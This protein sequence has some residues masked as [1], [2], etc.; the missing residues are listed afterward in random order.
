ML[1]T[2]STPCLVGRAFDRHMTEL[3]AGRRRDALSFEQDVVLFALEA[4]LRA[5]S[6]MPVAAP[7]HTFPL[8]FAAF[9]RPAAPDPDTCRAGE[10][11][12]APAAHA[13][14]KVPRHGGWADVRLD[15]AAIQHVVWLFA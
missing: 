14:N 9:A 6:R 8:A 4:F 10:R 3:Y 5:A 1:S 7:A 12:L 13:A 2:A 15:A 11:Q